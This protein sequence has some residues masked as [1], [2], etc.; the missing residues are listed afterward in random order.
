MFL[1][2]KQRLIRFRIFKLTGE[3]YLLFFST[4]FE[5]NYN[6]LIQLYKLTEIY[7]L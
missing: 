2:I 5:I 3:N 1:N 7:L 4:E 6:N